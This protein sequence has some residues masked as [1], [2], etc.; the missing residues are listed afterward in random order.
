M[1]LFLNEA[2]GKSLNVRR[3]YLIIGA[4]IVLMVIPLLYKLWWL[5]FLILVTELS[6]S[7]LILKKAFFSRSKTYYLFLFLL[8]LLLSISIKVFLF[9]LY[10]IPSPSMENTLYQGDRIFVSKLKIGPKMP[11][12]PFEIPWIN[13]FFYLSKTNREKRYEPWWD[14]K[15][16]DGISKVDRKD[17]IIFRLPDNNNEHYIKRCIAIPGDTLVIR[18]GVVYINGEMTKSPEGAKFH[19]WVWFNDRKKALNLLD[20]LKRNIY[21]GFLQIKDSVL[22]TTLCYEEA[23][24]LGLDTSIDSMSIK[25][26]EEDTIS[27][28]FPW[29]RR[30]NW[31]PENFGPYIIP[32]KGMKMTLDQNTFVLYR[33]AIT[34]FDCNRICYDKS[35]TQVILSGCKDYI[36]KNDYY[37]VMGD[38]R[39]NSN[40]SR[41]W[42]LVPEDQI[43]GVATMVLFSSNIRKT[44]LSRFFTRIE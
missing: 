33:N 4:C 13:L 25:I 34:K 5:F 43:I 17:V 11:N 23:L 26:T 14:T 40:D 22:E 31:T 42:G 24:F 15:R 44:G 8:L 28:A 36:F 12:S 9:E 39:H 35:G 20:S 6:F 27:S 16:L 7:F 30:F 37:F 19:Y 32:K 38:N 18:D 29:D 10:S 41:Y 3:R 1:Q 2:N 21:T